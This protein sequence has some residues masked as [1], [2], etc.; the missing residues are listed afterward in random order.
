MH[1][2]DL[3]LSIFNPETL[4][5]NGG[6]L[7][8]FLMVYG[9]TGVFFAFFLP[10]GA[11][12]F[13]TGVWTATGALHYSIGTICVTLIIAAVL[14]NISGYWFGRKTRS[15]L[16]NRKDSALFKRQHLSTAH[17]FYKKHGGLALA[18]GPFFPIIRTFSPIVAGMIKLDFRRFFLYTFLGSTLWIISFVLTGYFIGIIPG[19]KPFLPYVI[20]GVIL[21]VTLPIVIRIVRQWYKPKAKEP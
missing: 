12:L 13:T 2:L 7:I 11:L 21:V 8:I 15:W 6:L 14:G 19:L 5:A 4:I 17:D 9:Q 18:A 1:A 20:T 10:S 16:Y 3:L